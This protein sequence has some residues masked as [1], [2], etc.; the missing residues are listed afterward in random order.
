[1]TN[2]YDHVIWADCP[3]GLAYSFWYEECSS[4]SHSVL[5]W[6][7]DWAKTNLLKSPEQ[8]GTREGI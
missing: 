3:F 8:R 1:M 5:N 2:T 6:K 7:K 4:A